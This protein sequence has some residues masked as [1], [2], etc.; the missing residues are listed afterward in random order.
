M[1]RERLYTDLKVQGLGVDHLCTLQGVA[2]LQDLITH[3][4]RATITHELHR[5]LLEDMIVTYGVGITTLDEVFLM[6]ARGETAEKPILKSAKES[7]RSN[8]AY[9]DDLERSIRSRLE[10]ET[11]G[12]FVRHVGALFRKRAL[13]FKRDKKAWVSS[14]ANISGVLPGALEPSV[15]S[16]NSLFT[17][18][19]N[20][21]TKSVCA[22]WLSHVCIRLTFK[23]A[24]RS[25]AGPGSLQ[26]GRH[27][28][29]KKSYRVL[30]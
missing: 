14:Y 3:Q 27:L 12:L 20:N 29:P 1:H 15:D 10:L 5:G 16:N 17:V 13:N 21:T 24:R 2:H 8:V 7:D 11:E 28:C 18:L 30:R 19:H 23:R 4:L 26:C 25:H 22:G 6:V 9:K